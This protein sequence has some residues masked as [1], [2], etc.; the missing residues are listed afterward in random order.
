MS[1][2]K[3]AILLIPGA[4]HQGEAW[5]PVTNILQEQGYY[6]EPV[7]LPSAGGPPSTSVA[8]DA[9][10]IRGNH[11]ESLVAQGREVIIVMHSYGGVPGTESV[12]GFA[13]KDIAAQGKPGGVIALVYTAAF[14]I[15]G[16]QTLA[17]S[18][19]S[20]SPSLINQVMD[21]RA[22]SGFPQQG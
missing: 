7:T 9:A 20:D 19:P 8:D 10:Y 17:E 14:M 22:A 11:L 1:T 6:V 21:V 4:W 12:K 18:L 15:A 3:P 16:G 2:P 5:K 13:R